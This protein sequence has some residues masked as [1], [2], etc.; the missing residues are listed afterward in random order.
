MIIQITMKVVVVSNF[1]KDLKQLSKKGVKGASTIYNTDQIKELSDFDYLKSFDLGRKI[2]NLIVNSLKEHE[3]IIPQVGEVIRGFQ[4]YPSWEVYKT[5]Y[6]IDNKGKSGGLR[7]VYCLSKDKEVLTI[8]LVYIKTSSDSHPDKL[9][10]AECNN[11]ISNYL[12]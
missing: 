5:R 6:A 2:L 9:L 4:K 1:W 11:R 7:I 3:G 10:R 12:S 8:L